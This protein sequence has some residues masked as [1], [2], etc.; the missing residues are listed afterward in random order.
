M[1][2]KALL[3]VVLLALSGCGYDEAEESANNGA[4]PD[5]G[6]QLTQAISEEE[7]SAKTAAT[8]PAQSNA[9]IALAGRAEYM[10]GLLSGC[11]NHDYPDLNKAK[12]QQFCDCFHKATYA[13]MTDAEWVEW[14]ALM[15]EKGKIWGADFDGIFAVAVD[16]KPEPAAPDSA[17]KERLAR[18]DADWQQRYTQSEN[19][20]M[21]QLGVTVKLTY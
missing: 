6:V 2:V 18:F 3:L 17:L 15:V 1:F 5:F 8:A 14:D 21:K 20:C 10:Q 13:S 12:R 4:L 16:N 9:E 11:I 19:A 7:G